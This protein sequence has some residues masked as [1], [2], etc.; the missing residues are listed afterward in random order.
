MITIKKSVFLIISVLVIAALAVCGVIATKNRKA[1]LSPNPGYVPPPP[2]PELKI[3]NYYLNGDK[4]SGLWV[5][6]Y[7]NYLLIN[8]DDV[9][10]T[11]KA[12]MDADGITPDLWYYERT[13]EER[14]EQLCGKKLY[15][16]ESLGEGS[17][18]VSFRITPATD[19]ELSQSQMVVPDYRDDNEHY[20]GKKYYSY[21]Y[22]EY[23]GTDTMTFGPLGD[24]IIVD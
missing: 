8:G 16:V 9:E 11:I 13:L 12:W 19:E 20:A 15:S 22:Y 5:E 3:G 14:E 6:V 7:P 4:N 10:A 21:S 17:Y 1:A 23:N 2:P 24:F 18:F